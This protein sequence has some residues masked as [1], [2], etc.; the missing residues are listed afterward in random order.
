MEQLTPGRNTEM[1]MLM[2]KIEIKLSR[3]QVKSLI[4]LM[5]QYSYHQP[6]V[7]LDEKSSI[8]LVQQLYEKKIRRW[9]HSLKDKFK[10]SLD[11]AQAAALFQMFINLGLAEYPYELNLCNYITGE[12]HHQTC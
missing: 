8:F 1:V 4:V 9:R 10:L 5:A 11:I 6:M 2:K 7:T 3:E 12:I